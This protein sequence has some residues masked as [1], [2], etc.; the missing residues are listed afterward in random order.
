MLSYERYRRYLPVLLLAVVIGTASCFAVAAG[1]AA[2]AGGF[3]YYKGKL[4]RTY[5]KPVEKCYR[6]SLSAIKKLG[7]PILKESKDAFGA[8]IESQ[9]SDG[10]AVYIKI[11]GITDKT[12]EI[13]VRISLF[14]DEKK[15]TRILATIEQYL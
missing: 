2:G 7:L 9:M 6:A 15:S 12:T 3:A 11:K 5:S 13:S 14:G 1:G 4:V 8:S 10:K